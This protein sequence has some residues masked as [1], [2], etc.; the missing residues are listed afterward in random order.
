[1]CTILVVDGEFSTVGA[2]EREKHTISDA[3]GYIR[4]LGYDISRGG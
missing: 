4:H 2:E 3:P 1:M